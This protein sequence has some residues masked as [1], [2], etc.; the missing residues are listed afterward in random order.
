M[1]VEEDSEGYESESIAELIVSA[2]DDGR[3]EFRTKFENAGL[4]EALLPMIEENSREEDSRS[5]RSESPEVA[6]VHVAS[7]EWRA[8][9]SGDQGGR[10]GWQNTGG[11]DGRSVEGDEAS[12][13]GT[14]RR[15]ER[16]ERP[17]VVSP[18]E[19]WKITVDSG[20]QPAVV[21]PNL[22]YGS[23]G[24]GNVANA[25]AAEAGGDS[26]SDSRNDSNHVAGIVVEPVAE[27]KAQKTQSIPGSPKLCL[28]SPFDSKS[29]ARSAVKKSSS[30]KKSTR[31]SPLTLTRFKRTTLSMPASSN[32]TLASASLSFDD[33]A[34]ESSNAAFD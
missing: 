21:E 31:R 7:V 14:P 33:S 11:E 4:S 19:E 6:S 3:H 26:S 22:R 27:P 13:D 1:E 30:P 10:A 18:K 9:Q 32:A 8:S 28:K 5:S 15:R 12:E 17:L 29:P 20:E 25:G 34:M 2:E 24:L 23:S 16:L